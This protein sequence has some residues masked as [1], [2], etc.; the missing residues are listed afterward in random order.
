MKKLVCPVCGWSDFLKYD[1][2]FH[3]HCQI[4]ETGYTEDEI[5]GF[6]MDIPVDDEEYDGSIINIYLVEYESFGIRKPD[7]YY[8]DFIDNMPDSK[9]E[10]F[11][12][13]DESNET[14]EYETDWQ[15]LVDP[16]PFD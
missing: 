16:S 9:N 4:C 3:W 10:F 1:Y 7:K 15:V 2:E 13:D 12:G 6:L 8:R 14:E 11:I 5:L